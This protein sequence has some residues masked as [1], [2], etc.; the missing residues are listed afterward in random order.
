MNAD[1][2]AALRRFNLPVFLLVLVLVLLP[3]IMKLQLWLPLGGE[4][5]Y[6]GGDFV[7]L[8]HPW[9]ETSIDAWRDGLPL[10]TPYEGLGRPLHTN[11]QAAVFYPGT[12][13]AALLFPGGIGYF[14]AEIYLLLHLSIGAAGAFLLGRVLGL[15]SVFAAF[16]GALFIGGGFF[17]NHLTILAMTASAA[18]VPWALAASL[19]ALQ[20]GGWRWIPAAALAIALS[21]LGGLPQPSYYAVLFVS[22]SA[23]WF[24]VQRRRVAPA[25]K[26]ML[27]GLLAFAFTAPSLL[28]GVFE[29]PLMVRGGEWSLLADS[30]RQLP[31]RAVSLFAP[32]AADSL[33]LPA[34]YSMY[35]GAGALVLALA[36]FF[37]KELRH[38]GL[39]LAGLGLFLLIGF[40]AALS[41]QSIANLTLPGYSFFKEHERTGIM[42]NLFVAIFAGAGLQS[43]GAW[44]KAQ[45]FVAVGGVAMVVGVNALAWI[46]TPFLRVASVYL[47]QTMLFVVSAIAVGVAAFLKQRMAV[48]L[49]LVA[50]IVELL[51]MANT[52][53]LRRGIAEE[54]KYSDARIAAVPVIEGE[55][56]PRIAW[57]DRRD[58]ST[59]IIVTKRNTLYTGDTNQ[60]RSLLRFWSIVER[61]FDVAAQFDV[62]YLLQNRK[63]PPKYE[64]IGEGVYR[65][66]FALPR[67]HL[68]PEAAVFPGLPRVEE[69]LIAGADLQG[70]VLLLEDDAADVDSARWDDEQWAAAEADITSYQRRRVEIRVVAPTDAWLVLSDFYHHNWH[71]SLDGKDTPILRANFIARAVRVPA[72]RHIV[73]FR[74]ED[75]L[76]LLGLALA[77]L[78]VVASAVIIFTGRKGKRAGGDE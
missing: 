39:L 9:L 37:S 48:A 38:R 69:A 33:A 47:F 52:N 64:R 76:A 30:P 10:Y 68:V 14:G 65:M 32:N 41:L 44:S 22:L 36:G 12:V 75:P 66:N 35:A 13:L 49:A 8:S 26:Y 15:K 70:H 51:L 53:N 45:K 24:T 23:V 67:A 11:L 20:P 43:L 16:A 61:N 71:A 3:F 42:I 77:G 25:G 58:Q 4:L 62:R 55:P 2:G 21:V 31:A 63:L 56:P 54:M 19:K 6:F 28:P 57:R 27:I 18:W 5:R 7:R 74:F 46:I 60:Y 78:A 1:G 50:C 40:A 17:L 34:A 29:L 73:V 59:R 72:G